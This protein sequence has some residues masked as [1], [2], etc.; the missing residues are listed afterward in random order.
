MGARSLFIAGVLAACWIA[1]GRAEEGGQ[2]HSV[3]RSFRL[4]VA[5]TGEFTEYYG[6]KEAAAAA[7]RD[8]MGQVSA[9]YEREVGVRLPLVPNFTEMIF[10]DPASDPYT[11]N[12]P[13]LELLRE[14]QAAFD[15]IIGTGNYDLGI[16]LTRGHYGLT[17]LA[18]VC[19][20][21]L[22]GSTCFGLPEP[23]GGERHVNLIAHELAHQFGAA[24][25]FNSA[26]GFCEIRRHAWTAF[27][28]G[29]G[30][31]LMGYA[32]LECGDNSFQPVNDAYF[33]SES[34]KQIRDFLNSAAASCAIFT[35]TGNHPPSVNA[36][37]EFTIPILT[38]FAL[39][40]SGSDPDGD[41]VL[42]CWE[43]RDLGPARGLHAPDDGTGP[44][45]RS[46]PPTASP[47]RI[48]P[49]L[50]YILSGEPAPGEQ[51]PSTER[52]LRFR[53]TARDDAG[54][55]AF[56]WSDTQIFVEDSAGPFRFLSH[57]EP[58]LIEGSTE[59]RWDPAG[60]AQ[61]PIAATQV[62]ISLSLDGGFSF[63]ILLAES[64]PNDGAELVELPETG[65]TQA[66]IKV[67]AV[68]NIFFAINSADLV[69]A[70]SGDIR[71]TEVRRNGE[72]LTIE[73]DAAPGA[74]Y[75]IQSARTLQGPWSPRVEVQ[76][77]GPAGTAEVPIE[78]GN[79]FFRV[80]RN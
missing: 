37:P 46:Y 79:E 48:F 58:A 27:E 9:I 68:E 16:V 63:P 8:I 25:T 47:T 32:G 56:A 29:T 36:G 23:D 59:I 41:A 74:E 71:I 77:D 69:L 1:A 24:H 54:V 19:D 12:E 73:W 30:S 14:A 34:L 62:H 35:E 40:A 61:T 64:T 33:H 75:E 60:T 50:P 80:R 28:P 38:P 2:T 42:Y 53:I 78:P 45:F 43:Q 70:G 10:E 4:A 76:T 66:R 44:L 39:T 22:K 13:S 26:E 21:R 20:P 51:L 18:S 55:G 72:T 15:S 11:T 65:S 67:E 31:T 6:G 57:S 5:A 52:V 7:V 49:A 3:L 17:H